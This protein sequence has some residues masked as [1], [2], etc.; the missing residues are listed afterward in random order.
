M[1]CNKLKTSPTKGTDGISSLQIPVP[2]L[3]DLSRNSSSP[4]EADVLIHRRWVFQHHDGTGG[5]IQHSD[6]KVTL[7]IPEVRIQSHRNEPTHCLHL[8]HFSLPLEFFILHFPISKVH[9]SESVRK[10]EKEWL[11]DWGRT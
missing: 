4:Q 2:D 3:R 11:T 7:R 6:Q 9:F 5:T 10:R 1:I 8:M